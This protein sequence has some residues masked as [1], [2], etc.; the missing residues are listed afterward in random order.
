MNEHRMDD[1]TLSDLLEARAADVAVGPPPLAEIHRG[2]RRRRSYGVLVA[3]AAAAAVVGA[4][5]LWPSAS[6]PGRDPAP[7]ASDGASPDVP[8]AGFRW[9]GMGRAAIAVPDAWGTNATRC[10]VP[11]RD[12]VVVDVG[13][14]ETCSAAY[15]AEVTSV[16]L[17]VP[18]DL[19]QLLEWS[20]VEV[21]G[22]QA[23]HTASTG[24]ETYAGRDVFSSRVQLPAEG[25]VFEATSTV[26]QR[27]V[28]EALSRIVVLDSHVAVPGISPANYEHPDQTKAGR[29][30]VRAVQEAGLVAKVVPEPTRDIP[31]GFVLAASPAPGTVVEPG[32]VVTV[33]V[34]R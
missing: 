13:V 33:E 28:D 7:V 9:V 21:D 25:V 16:T 2:G 4:V 30:Y 27:A 31:P 10:G 18:N 32:S 5:A 8:P 23:L 14:V 19:D 29:R 26:S 1:Q 11:T 6:D 12:T 24:S 34:T 22:E 15:P 20:R 17:R 3:A